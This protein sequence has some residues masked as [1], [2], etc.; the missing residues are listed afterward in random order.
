MVDW[1]DLFDRLQFE[2]DFVLDD[3]IGTKSLMKFNVVVNDRN[4]NLSSDAQSRFFSSYSST[5]S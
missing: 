4:L 3:E 5:V 1:R 2:N